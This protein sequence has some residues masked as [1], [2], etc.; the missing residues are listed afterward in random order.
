MITPTPSLPME[1]T[2]PTNADTLDQ[3]NQSETM[4]EAIKRICAPYFQNALKEALKN[5]MMVSRSVSSVLEPILMQPHNFRIWYDY[6]KSTFSAPKELYKIVNS[7]E[8]FF[9]SWNDCNIKIKK[10]TIEVTNKINHKHIDSIST[11]E[12][13]LT[14]K[15]YK[16]AIDKKEEECL[17]TLKL[18]IKSFGGSSDYTI[19]NKRCEIK[20]ADGVITK[21]INPKLVWHSKVSKKV[22]NEQNIEFFNEVKANIY[23]D[24]AALKKFAP[25]IEANLSMMDRKINRLYSNFI[26]AIEQLTATQREFAENFKTHVPVMQGTEKAMRGVN[27]GFRRFNSLLGQKSTQKRLTEPFKPKEQKSMTD[28]IG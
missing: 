10:N 22:Y 20:V 12:S 6:N 21:K 18:F 2:N 15:E 5:P 3:R 19:I 27:E 16:T 1:T 8:I 14:D 7:K 24:N 9:K 25:V 23:I 11:E 26:P 4:E 13:H 28:Y 17:N